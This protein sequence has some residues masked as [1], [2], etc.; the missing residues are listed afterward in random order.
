MFEP[1]LEAQSRLY[2]ASGKFEQR[3]V[4]VGIAVILVRIIGIDHRVGEIIDLL[5]SER[6]DAIEE[7]ERGRGR[8]VAERRIE[9]AA[10][11]HVDTR[12]L[13]CSLRQMLPVAGIQ[14]SLGCVVTLQYVTGFPM[15]VVVDVALEAKANTIGVRHLFI[16]TRSEFIGCQVRK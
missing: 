5:G 14:G 13:T 6:S 4:D 2:L 12:R 9:G 15:I 10:A 8:K 16:V 7:I 1:A 3:A 11:R